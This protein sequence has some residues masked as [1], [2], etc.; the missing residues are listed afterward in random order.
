MEDFTRAL[1]AMPVDV[2]GLNC[3]SGPSVILETLEQMSAYTNKTLSAMPNAGLGKNLFSPEYLASCAARFV[4]AGASI[5]GGCCGTTPE[6][7]KQIRDTVRDAQPVHHVT[8]IPEPEIKP[9][10][11]EKLPLASKSDLGAKLAAGTFVTL[12]EMPIRRAP[13][14]TSIRPENP[15]GP[16]IRPARESDRPENPTGTERWACPRTGSARG[17]GRW[18]ERPSR[19]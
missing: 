19:R 14:L 6:H 12:V 5:V 11:M 17:S 8:F 7:I 10:P 9:E 4:Q 16:R 1:D 18:S 2:I 15:T 13:G 3:S